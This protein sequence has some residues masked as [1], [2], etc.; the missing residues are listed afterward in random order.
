MT[1]ITKMMRNYIH[2][3]DSQTK[4]DRKLII[5]K[6]EKGLVRD[7]KTKQYLFNSVIFG[8]FIQNRIKSRFSKDQRIYNRKFTLEIDWTEQNDSSSYKLF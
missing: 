7:P 1:D 8:E 4:E 6:I 3:F 2:S 5:E